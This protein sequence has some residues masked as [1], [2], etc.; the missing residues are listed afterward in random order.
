M[1]RQRAQA[2]VE[3]GLISFVLFLMFFVIIDGARAV[4]SWQTVSEAAREGAHT[5]ELTD[6]TD[7][8][9]RTA[10][11]SHTGLLGNLGGG[12]TITPAV[13]RTALQTVTISVSYT[14]QFVTPF[15]KGFGPITFTSQTVV[16]AE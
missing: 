2:L 6:S 5:A 13:T 8:Q 15:L 4:Y 11:N 12:A 16:I 3:F 9:I 7:T 1:S 10:I 14:Y